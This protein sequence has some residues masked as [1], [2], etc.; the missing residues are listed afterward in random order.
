MDE[1]KSVNNCDVESVSPESLSPDLYLSPQT[2]RYSALIAG[3]IYGK[4]R[5]GE[6]RLELQAADWTV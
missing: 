2:A 4:R 3:I 5:Y 1:Q 6:W